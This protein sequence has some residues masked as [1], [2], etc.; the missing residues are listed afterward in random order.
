MKSFFVRIL[1]VLL[2]VGGILA[3]NGVLEQRALSEENARLQAELE[4]ANLRLEQK[5]QKTEAEAASA[6]TGAY[7]D[8]V[9]E[10]TATGFGGD[11]TVKVTVEQGKIS[12]LEIVSAEQED[13]AYLGIASGIVDEIL[14]KQSADVDTISGATFSSTGIK[15][16]AAAALK[17]ARG[18][19]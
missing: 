14:E 19:E 3:Y 6:E 8:G 1:N 15:D 5:A 17:E 16:A 13:K 4:S 9:Y 12:D 18:E 10:G 2:V 7:T 11:I